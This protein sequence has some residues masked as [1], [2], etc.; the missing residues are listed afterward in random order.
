VRR[1]DVQKGAMWCMIRASLGLNSTSNAQMN[2]T[3]K[4]GHTYIVN[5]IPDPE[6]GKVRFGI[7]DKG[8]Q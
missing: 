8:T 6:N 7:E 1:A 3:T 5:A 4:A 2:V